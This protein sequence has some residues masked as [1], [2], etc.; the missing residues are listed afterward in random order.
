MLASFAAQSDVRGQL[1]KAL[2]AFATKINGGAS[3]VDAEAYIAHWQKRYADAQTG[4]DSEAIE[5][6]KASE[7]L[8]AALR[9]VLN[10][11]QPPKVKAL[12]ERRSEDE[13]AKVRPDEPVES[14][15]ERLYTAFRTGRLMTDKLAQLVREHTFDPFG[16]YRSFLFDLLRHE[17]EENLFRLDG[18]PTSRTNHLP[19]MPLL[20]GDNPL[21]N[22]LPSKFLRLTDYQLYLLRQWSRGLFFNEIEEGW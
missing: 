7:E 17:G 5:Y 4:D 1:L 19:L 21:S 20:N 3:I 16:P 9:E 14:A 13:P 10:A 12:L 2:K 15:I 22:T 6:K 18:R 11:L 8:F